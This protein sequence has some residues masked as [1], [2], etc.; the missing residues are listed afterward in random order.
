M[1]PDDPSAEA[2]FKEVAEAFEV[3]SDDEKRPLYDRYGHEGLSGASFRDFSGMGL[4]DL[5]GGFG[6]FENL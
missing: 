4:D 1:N 3:L 6:I 2:K 5:F